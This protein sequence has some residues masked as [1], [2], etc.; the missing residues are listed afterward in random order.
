M[1]KL[2]IARKDP[3]IDNGDGARGYQVIGDNVTEGKEI[4][5]KRSTGTDPSWTTILGHHRMSA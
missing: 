4:G 1:K 2:A 5:M 3:G